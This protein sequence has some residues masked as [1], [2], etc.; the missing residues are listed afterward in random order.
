MGKGSGRRPMVVSGDEFKE[1]WRQC[2]SDDE[3]DNERRQCFSFKP[4][5]PECGS[6]YGEL[7]RDSDGKLIAR[8]S[9]GNVQVR[10]D[11]TGG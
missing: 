8:C 11:H 3:S 6:L 10:G 5:C 9:C 4:R 7:D 2:F 1:N